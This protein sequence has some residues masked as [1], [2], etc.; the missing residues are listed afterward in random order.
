MKKLYVFILLLLYCQYLQA[1]TWTGTI[2]TDWNTA[3]NWSPVG[4]PTPSGNVIIPPSLGNYPVM[5][6]KVTIN[7]ID[8][9]PGSRLDVN[10]SELALSGLNSNINFNGATLNNSNG[11][12]DIVLTINTGTGGFLTYFGSNIINDNIIFNLGGSNNFVESGTLPANVYNGHVTLNINDILTVYTSY[13]APSQ[14]NGNLTV[15]RT[16]AGITSLFYSGASI[17]GN[18][19]Y[20][21]NPGSSTAMGN[22]A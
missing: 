13:S 16:V 21:N 2:S 11:A 18:F 5:N 6:G 3:D 4:V 10:G 20:T 17:T 19:S 22:P 9:Q 12:T 1:Q 14:Y 7:S 8:M 15:N